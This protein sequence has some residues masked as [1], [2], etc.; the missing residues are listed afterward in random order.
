MD[1]VYFQFFG[2]DPFHPLNTPVCGRRLRCG[3]VP[4]A[5]GG[6]GGLFRHHLCHACGDWPWPREN[7]QTCRPEEDVQGGKKFPILTCDLRP[8]WHYFLCTSWSLTHHSF[9]FEKRPSGPW[10]GLD[11]SLEP[12]TEAAWTWLYTANTSLCWSVLGNAALK[13][14]F[15]TK[16][17]IELNYHEKNLVNLSQNTYYISNVTFFL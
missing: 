16:H 10:S 12:C 9:S 8:C 5:G 7:P 1:L 15:L 14:F 13:L 11:G 4:E 2:P 3:L 6:G 17:M